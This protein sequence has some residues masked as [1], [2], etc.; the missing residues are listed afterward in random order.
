MKKRTIINLITLI[1]TTF[2][3]IFVGRAWYVTNEKATVS[4][5]LATSES[6][7][8]TLEL[9]RGTYNVAD[10][11][12]WTWSENGINNL[13]INSMQPGDTSF[14]RFKITI[15][16]AS[17]FKVSVDEVN[18][19]LQENVLTR[20]NVGTNYYV[21]LNNT[22]LYKMNSATQCKIYSDTNETT[23]LGV[24][25][26]YDTEEEKFTLDDFK[27][28]SAFRF[29]DYGLHDDTYFN[30][31]DN[32]VTNDHD[33]TGDGKEIENLSVTYSATGI[34]GTVVRYG[35]FALEF[36]D[37]A[38]MKTYK[39]LDGTVKADSNLY[40]AQ[41]MEIKKFVLQEL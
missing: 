41:T 36:N 13:S 6:N 35:Y 37:A 22:K 12:K 11:P 7:S 4:N 17:N 16:K 20:E 10:T 5:I 2:L 30:T 31:Q 3:L 39:H 15:S 32:I 34:T 24:L 18:S 38:S 26:N 33:I 28:Q 14:F 8:F 23:E 27:V 1:I 25:Y 9:Q 40:Q 29:Y 21:M 19:I